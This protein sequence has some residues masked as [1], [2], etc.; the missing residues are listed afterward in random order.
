MSVVQLERVPDIVQEGVESLHSLKMLRISVWL[1]IGVFVWD[2][3]SCSVNCPDGTVCSDHATCCMTK[4]GFT[5]CQ[6]PNAV[7]CSDQAHCCPFGFHCNLATQ[8]CE[9]QGQLWMQIPMVKKEA[10]EEQA[11]P[12]LPM[13][14]LQEPRNDQVPEASKSS[15]V[16]CDSY[17]ICPDSTT[18]CRHPAGAWF[19]CPYSP[20]RCC[21]DGYHCC[22][23]GYDCDYSY[24]HCVRRGL[25][26]PFTPRQ[27]LSSV[28]A[29]LISPPDE[30]VSFQETPMTAL[31][32]ASDSSPEA[33][34]IRC[35]SKF[36]CPNGMT[37][38]KGSIYKW[39]CCPHPLGQCCADGLHCCPYG[40]TCDASLTCRAFYSVLPSGSHE[41]LKTE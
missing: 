26:Y 32:E 20:G 35:D 31:T 10:A 34:V 33:G 21:L 9:K 19:C 18:C 14:S 30:E 24:T 15:V 41:H 12:V 1:L 7:C 27:A 39:T 29:T 3:A 28:P 4:Y 6:Y 37:C 8:M 22:P 38:C 13:S 2:F 16:H 11:P 40:Y 36:Y 23:Y 25:R 5:C 17:Y